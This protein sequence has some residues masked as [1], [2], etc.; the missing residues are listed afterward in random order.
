MFS[1]SVQ[2]PL[3]IASA[4]KSYIKKAVLP[5]SVKLSIGM[6]A[7]K[8]MVSVQIAQAKYNHWIILFL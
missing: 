2:D 7:Q 3:E 8:C 5:A 1:E 6:I 4:V